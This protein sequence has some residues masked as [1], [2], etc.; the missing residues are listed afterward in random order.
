MG[1]SV[2]FFFS[3]VEDSILFCY[4]CGE[5]R[6]LTHVLEEHNQFGFSAKP[7]KLDHVEIQVSE[8]KKVQKTQEQAQ[9]HTH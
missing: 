2:S 9:G 6:E 8:A 5:R 3:I 1:T 7:N 4:V